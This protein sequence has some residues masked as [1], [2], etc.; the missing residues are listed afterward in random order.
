MYMLFKRGRPAGYV[1]HDSYESAR[2]RLRRLQR[3]VAH[4][5]EFHLGVSDGSWEIRKV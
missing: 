2:N 5:G 4:N 3:R 1:K